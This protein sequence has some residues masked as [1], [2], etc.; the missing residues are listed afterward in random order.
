MMT[1]TF[2]P[3]EDLNADVIFS[4]GLQGNAIGMYRWKST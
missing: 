2:L 3:R 1:N 4:V